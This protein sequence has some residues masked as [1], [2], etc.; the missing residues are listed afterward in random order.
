MDKETQEY[1]THLVEARQKAFEDFDKTVLTLSGGALAV[2]ITFV[3]DL[4]GPGAL[5]YERCLLSAWVCWGVSV[6]TVL[7]SYYSSQLTLNRAI[8]QID[9][10][11]R[12][13]RPGG[14]FRVFTLTLNAVGGLLFLAGLILLIV[15]VSRNLEV[16]NV[17]QK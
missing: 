17:R 14:L 7:V 1:R 10:G 6:L 11:T 8:N 3:K 12:S 13:S 9:S 2:S 15:F 5:S 4:L 16:L